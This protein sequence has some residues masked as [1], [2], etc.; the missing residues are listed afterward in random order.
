MN[1]AE[2]QFSKAGQIMG[3]SVMAAGRGVQ[4]AVSQ[5]KQ[6]PQREQRDHYSMCA[7]QAAGTGETL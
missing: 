2:Q 1:W 6:R 4:K 5:P 7:K 3:K